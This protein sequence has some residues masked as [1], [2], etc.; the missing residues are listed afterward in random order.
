[1]WDCSWE[2]HL[3]PIKEELLKCEKNI[4][5]KRRIAQQNEDMQRKRGISH[6]DKSLYGQ[7]KEEIS[8]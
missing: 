2:K 4:E 1:M 7:W 6:Q 5:E 3:M 8:E